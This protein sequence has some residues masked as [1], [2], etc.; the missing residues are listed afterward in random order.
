MF[1]DKYEELNFKFLSPNQ[2]IAVA[3]DQKPLVG[4]KGNKQT[5]LE[6]FN[7]ETWTTKTKALRMQTMPRCVSV[8]LTMIGAEIEVMCSLFP[9][10]LYCAKADANDKSCKSKIYPTHKLCRHNPEQMKEWE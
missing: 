5:L 10:C 8:V 3:S 6:G 9:H 1:N 4:L 2:T 7:D